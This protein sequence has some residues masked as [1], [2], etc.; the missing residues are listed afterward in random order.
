[1]AHSFEHAFGIE[2]LTVRVAPFKHRGQRGLDSQQFPHV[3]AVWFR[4]GRFAV[5]ESKRSDLDACR[6]QSELQKPGEDIRYV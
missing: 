5:R 1:M 6:L 3:G 4:A 2:I